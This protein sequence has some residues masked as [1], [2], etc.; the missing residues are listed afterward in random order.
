MTL[1]QASRAPNL[2][3]LH[4]DEAPSV[5]L[6]AG[7]QG[8]QQGWS[9]CLWTPHPRHSTEHVSP[10]PRHRHRSP[11]LL[12]TALMSNCICAELSPSQASSCPSIPSR[13]Q[14]RPTRA[15]LDTSPPH[16]PAPSTSASSATSHSTPALGTRE[17]ARILHRNTAGPAWGEKRNSSGTHAL[18]AALSPLCSVQ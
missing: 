8:L 7:E 2:L 13:D 15:Q 12:P 9:G 4:Q 10:D 14:D 5:V 11:A 3:R 6:K 1:T 18:W 17:H 16:P